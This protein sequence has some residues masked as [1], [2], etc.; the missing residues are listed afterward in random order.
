MDEK[1]RHFKKDFDELALQIRERYFTSVSDFSDALS[2]AIMKPFGQGDN[3]GSAEPG[4]DAIH[5]RLNEVKPGTA[6]HMALT[7]EQKELKRTARRISK[8]V[9]EPIREA[10]RKEAELKGREHEEEIKKLDSMGIF[11]AAKSSLAL[12]ESPIKTNG[13]RQ[14]RSAS[15]V[16]AAAGASPEDADADVEMM[17]ADERTEDEGVIHLNVAG[18]ED[19]VPVPNTGKKKKNT[20]A[21]EQAMSCASSSHKISAPPAGRA[22][23]PTEPLSPPDSA[24]S[25]EDAPTEDPADVFAHG[26]VPWYLSAF[27]P[28]G[29]TVHEERYTG[30]AVL[31]AMSEELSD[32]D[33]AT[34]TELAGSGVGETPPTSTATAGV[35]RRATRSSAVGVGG[36]VGVVGGEEEEVERKR[37]KPVRKGRR[38]QWTKPRVR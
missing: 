1:T 34:L 32:M 22:T 15:D 16:S 37:K 24:S 12:D 21:S 13:K 30:R 38:L 17:D 7:Q 2:G 23:G 5:T 25:V 29:T 33:E 11:A 3:T 6:E 10:L 20:P 27:D 9:Q 19:T 14:S 18:K 4:L 36:N 28:E 26:G 35:G 8:A 31:R